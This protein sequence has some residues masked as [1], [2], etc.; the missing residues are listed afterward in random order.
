[1]FSSPSYSDSASSSSESLGAGAPM[2]IAREEGGGGG[3]KEGG[4]EVGTGRDATRRGACWVGAGSN[5]ISGR[6][7][8]R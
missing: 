1:M 4:K 2:G 6:A 7:N 5:A 8:D 3:W